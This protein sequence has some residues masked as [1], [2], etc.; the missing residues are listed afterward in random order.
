MN[1]QLLVID[2]NVDILNIFKLLLSGKGYKVRTSSKGEYTE[3]LINGKNKLPDLIILDIMLGDKDGRDIC[4][5][6]KNSPITKHIPIIMISSDLTSK[7]SSLEANAN[8]FIAKPF[9]NE[10]VIRAIK[11]Y[12]S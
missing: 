9:E 4:K 1:K 5:K 6:L 7:K 12:L 10:T 11:S 3:D 2:D 8:S